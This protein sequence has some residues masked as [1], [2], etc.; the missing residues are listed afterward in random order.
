VFVLSE[1][2]NFTQAAL[3]LHVSQP[4]LSTQ[5]R[6]L[7]REINVKLFERTRRPI[8]KRFNMEGNH[9]SS[10][11]EIADNCLDRCMPPLGGRQKH[12]DGDRSTE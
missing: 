4:T 8:L 9:I 1:E 7:E 12:F 5:V 3:R 11:H 2:L 6:D 10:L